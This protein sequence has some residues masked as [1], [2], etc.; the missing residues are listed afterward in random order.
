MQTRVPDS[1]N[2]FDILDDREMIAT[3]RIILRKLSA[4]MKKRRFD[5]EEPAVRLFPRETD[6][7][8]IAAH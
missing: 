3:R 5:A 1:N 7:Q 8:S 4:R 6:G 2:S